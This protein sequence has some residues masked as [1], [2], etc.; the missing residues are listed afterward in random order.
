MLRFFLSESFGTNA[1]ESVQSHVIVA[2]HGLKILRRIIA[3]I[4]VDVMNIISWRKQLTIGI[5]P[6]FSMFAHVS[7]FASEM[8]IRKIYQPIS[9]PQLT[10]AIGSALLAAPIMIVDIFNRKSLEVSESRVGHLRNGST[11]AA[12]TGA[13]PAVDLISGW[14]QFSNLAGV[15]LDI[16]LKFQ[17][18]PRQK[19]G[20]RP[21]QSRR[22]RFNNSAA[23]TF[24]KFLHCVNIPLWGDYRQV[25]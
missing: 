14:N 11:L 19:S 4:F 5:L 12:T 6:Y 2:G 8:M 25:V 7:V 22:L 15:V 10:V 16:A 9:T 21:A 18:M 17:M 3:T 23:A 20:Q 1:P 24:T 13:D